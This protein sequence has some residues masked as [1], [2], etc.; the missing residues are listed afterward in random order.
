LKNRI[1]PATTPRGRRYNNCFMS[2][3]KS[4]SCLLTSHAKNWQQWAVLSTFRLGRRKTV[5]I[6]R[7]TYS[8]SID[9]TIPSYTS[10]QH[11]TVDEKQ[12]W[13]RLWH[14]FT[15]LMRKVEALYNH[16]CWLRTR[17]WKCHYQLHSSPVPAH[18]WQQTKHTDKILQ[19]LAITIMLCT[20]VASDSVFRSS[21]ER[22]P[23]KPGKKCPSVRTFIHTSI[24]KHNAATNQIVVFVKVDETFTTIWLSRS[25]EIRVKVTW[26]FK[27]QKWRFS[28]YISSTI[29]QP[30]K[31]N[32]N[33]FW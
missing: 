27:L 2:I 14:T 22:W 4:S 19:T 15:T 8:I 12:Q 32:S 33:G 24:M 6:N 25:S 31:K 20:K 5:L 23:N 29:F 21:P 30:I 9:D 1:P 28:N 18:V 11:T 7:V 3:I 17:R 10:V 26:D 16:L 13:K